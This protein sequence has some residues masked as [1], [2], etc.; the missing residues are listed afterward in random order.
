[1][2]QIKFKEERKM[3]YEKMWNELKE[4]IRTGNLTLKNMRNA[5]D[6]ESDER[7]RLAGKVEGVSLVEGWMSDL[8]KIS[9]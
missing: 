8:E 7:V 5:V 4:T 9:R 3:D 2:I 6:S 1:L